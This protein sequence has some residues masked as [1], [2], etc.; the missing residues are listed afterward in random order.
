[1]TVDWRDEAR[2]LAASVERITS[3]PPSETWLTDR[4]V[5]FRYLPARSDAAPI[6]LAI[7]EV[8]VV[9]GAGRGT[10]VELDGPAASSQ[11]VESLA[12]AVALGHLSEVVNKRRVTFVLR[13]P[14][15]PVIKGTSSY[16][17][18]RLPPPYG[19]FHYAPYER[20]R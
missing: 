5:E 19:A 13:P 18:G 6:S 8:E 4:L 20:P 16:L 17:R 9:F 11:E 15:R 3:I 1:M 12:S 10:R 14:D 7:S 2:Q